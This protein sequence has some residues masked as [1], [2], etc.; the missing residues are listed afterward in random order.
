MKAIVLGFAD[1]GAAALRL[2]SM[3]SAPFGRVDIHRFP[4]HESL[5]R[6]PRCAETTIFYRS[7]NEPDAKLIELILAASAAR[8]SGA[9]RVILVAPYLAYMRQDKA[10]RAG[11]AVSQR[12]ICKLLAAHFDAVVTVDPHLHRIAKLAEV[13]PDI[14][15]ITL[16]AAPLLAGLVDI[17][18][19]PLIMAPDGEANQWMMRVAQPL[20][21]V[22]LR[23][24]KKRLGDRD[25]QLDIDGLDGVR[26]RAIILVDDVIASGATMM[27]AA[28][29]LLSAGATGVE[30]LVTHCLA[31]PE[32]LARLARQGITRISSTDSVEGPTARVQLAAL[33]ASALRHARLLD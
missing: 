18:K 1:G 32:D 31:S 30:A 33:I 9:Q 13:M 15:T 5:V 16:S 14:V 22:P 12:V 19:R 2:A 7:L 4:D 11:E 25:V 6:V 27:A 10:F 28:G 26:G 3:L 23:A 17:G 29:Q 24:S 21:L 8:D 20:G